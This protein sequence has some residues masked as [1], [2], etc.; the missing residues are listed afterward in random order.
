VVPEPPEAPKKVKAKAQLVE[1]DLPALTHLFDSKHPP[2]RRVRSK[3][4][5]EVYYG[6]GDASQDG[7]GFNIQKPDD[8]TIHYRFG[9]WCDEISERL[10]NYREHFNLVC[11][12][13]ELVEEGPLGGS[14]VFL[15]TDNTTAEPVYYKGNPVSKAL[16]ELLLRL[17]NLEMTGDLVLHVVHVA[18]TRMQGEGMDGASRGKFTTRV[19]AGDHRNRYPLAMY[20]QNITLSL[21]LSNI[22]YQGKK[23]LGENI[24]DPHVVQFVDHVRF[25]FLVGR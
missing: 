8:D 3:K 10:S 11:R 18:G 25:S 17:H 13:E 2:K 23:W 22:F 14:E 24:T 15:F 19:M 5:A 1:C 20:N 12:L 21:F 9:Q 7:S 4:V 6:F 16:F